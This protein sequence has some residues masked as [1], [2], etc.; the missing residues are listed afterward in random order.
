[1]GNRNLRKQVSEKFKE[2][3]YGKFYSHLG[4]RKYRFARSG[5]CR[6]LLKMLSFSVGDV[7][8][9]YGD[10]HIIKEIPSPILGWY[11]LP[12]GFIRA[13]M[14]QFVYEDGLWSCGCGWCPDPAM[15]KEHIDARHKYY[16]S[17]DNPWWGI[18]PIDPA[19]QK[20]FDAVKNGISMVDERGIS[21]PEYK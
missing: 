17:H 9:D 11:N 3:G 10:N 16:Y 21:L 5:A 7:V 4:R 19:T 8:S 6:S 13:E 20:K 1:M 18:S 12:R 14:P 2:R 15:T